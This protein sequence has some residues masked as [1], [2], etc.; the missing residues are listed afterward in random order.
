MILFPHQKSDGI[1]VSKVRD[2]FSRNDGKLLK[3]LLQRENFEIMRHIDVNDY[4]IL[5]F[6]EP[7]VKPFTGNSHVEFLSYLG[8]FYKG[9]ILNEGYIMSGPV[10]GF[11]VAYAIFYVKK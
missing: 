2:D 8:S 6:D 4:T 10:H 11:N 9:L 7:E 1:S 5:A 3:E